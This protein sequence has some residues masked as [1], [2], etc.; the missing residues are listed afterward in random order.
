MYSE[1]FEILDVYNQT[2]TSCGW[3]EPNRSPKK[4]YF[5][6]VIGIYLCPSFMNTLYIA[7]PW[8]DLVLIGV[9]MN[10]NCQFLQNIVIQLSLHFTPGRVSTRTT[11]F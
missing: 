6:C 5:S 4:A 2:V 9:I 10:I 8:D 11:M 3:D 1:I 7:F